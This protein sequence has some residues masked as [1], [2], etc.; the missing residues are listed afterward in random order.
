MLCAIC[1]IALLGATPDLHPTQNDMAE[2]SAALQKRAD[3]NR[4]VLAEYVSRQEEFNRKFDSLEKNMEELDRRH[5]ENMRRAY[6]QPQSFL[7]P[8]VAGLAL[9]MAG[10]LCMMCVDRLQCSNLPMLR[11][12][13][14]RF[15][16]L[17]GLTKEYAMRSAKRARF[18]SAIVWSC[19]LLAVLGGVALLGFAL[20]LDF[21]SEDWVRSVLTSVQMF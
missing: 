21:G 14:T 3:E 8:K 4:R 11:V 6:R 20:F 19:A 15:G 9:V 16:L 10:G 5:D 2:L 18:I 7:W 17:I 12:A 1:F 13:D